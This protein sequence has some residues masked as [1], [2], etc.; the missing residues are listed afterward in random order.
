MRRSDL[1]GYQLNKVD[2]GKC[3]SSGCD[4]YHV[5]GRILCDNC[6]IKQYK[7]KHPIKYAYQSLR[8]NAKHRG[9]VFTISFEYFKEFC[10]KTK[11]LLGRGR[12]ADS[13]HIDRIKE[14]L[15]YVE[16]N[17]QV[18]TN[19][20]NLRKYREYDWHTKTGHTSTRLNDNDYTDVP[21]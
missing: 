7:A 16:G 4:K 17:L 6:R 15:G 14:E 20:E 8:V 21:F 5:K 3:A 12:N 10:I 11:I 9:K 13:Y 19:T 2:R 18:L 1:T